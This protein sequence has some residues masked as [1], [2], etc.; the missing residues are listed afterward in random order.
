MIEIS[1]P[2]S[3]ISSLKIDKEPLDKMIIEAIENP[4]ESPPLEKMLEKTKSVLILTDDY[5]RSTP[6]N[7]ILPILIRKIESCGIKSE[8]IAIL[9]ALGT[10]RPMNRIE[11][12]AKLGKE[13]CTRYKVLNHEWWDE[14]KLVSLGETKNRTPVVVNKMVKE[15]DFIIGIGQIVPHRVTGLSGGANIVQPGICGEIT[16]GKTHWLAAQF[17]GREILGKIE[18]PVKDEVEKVAQMA[19]LRWIINTIQDAQGNVVRIVTGDPLLAYRNGGE[20]SISVY[21]AELPSE[22]DIVITDSFPL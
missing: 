4:I 17:T 9:I 22:A 10:H 2:Y 21:K 6:T 11:M 7:K 20:T 1:F 19:G 5:T 14:T 3:E 12:E 16:T 18:N 8:S 13:I 15:F